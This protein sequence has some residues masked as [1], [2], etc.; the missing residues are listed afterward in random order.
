MIDVVRRPHEL[1][2]RLDGGEQRDGFAHQLMGIRG[3]PDRSEID[4]GSKF[5]RLSIYGCG[6]QIGCRRE[7]SYSSLS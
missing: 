2:G 7:P 4:S 6:G 3:A 1:N 5:K